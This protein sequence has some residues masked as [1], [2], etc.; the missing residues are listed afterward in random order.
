MR[1]MNG[2]EHDSAPQIVEGSE[3]GSAATLAATEKLG[4]DE[5]TYTT[6]KLIGG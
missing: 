6:K 5:A 1:L 4:N 2:L 3:K